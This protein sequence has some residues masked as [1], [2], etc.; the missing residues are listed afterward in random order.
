MMKIKTFNELKRTLTRLNKSI[1]NMDNHQRRLYGSNSYDYTIGMSKALS[2]F[3]DGEYEA[4]Q[5]IL[6]ILNI[7]IDILNMDIVPR[8]SQRIDSMTTKAMSNKPLTRE[9]LMTNYRVTDIFKD[10]TLNSINEDLPFK[11]SSN[12]LSKIIREVFPDVQERKCTND[13]KYNME[14]IL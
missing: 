5:E 11:L 3:Q 8:G 4:A 14:V 2:L 10:V 7:G 13:I 1:D 9:I 12:A 6:A